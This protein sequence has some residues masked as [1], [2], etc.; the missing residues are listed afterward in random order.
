[1]A[2]KTEHTSE[3]ASSG[4][5][6]RSRRAGWD[7]SLMVATVGLLGALGLQS[8]VGTLYSWWAYRTVPGWEQTGY[9]GFIDVM[10]LIAGPLVIAL[11]V[12]MGLC[13]PK[14]LFSRRT[15]LAVSAGM[16]ALGVGVSV[17]RG[18]FLTGLGVYLGV[19]AFIQVAVVVLTIADAGGLEY[20][21]EGRLAKVGSG[22]LHLGFIVFA[23][24][25]VAL[26]S[27][28]MMMLAFMTSG[29]LLT[30]GSAMSF[31][32]RSSSRG[33]ADER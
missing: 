26:Q 13:V 29:V 23:L 25:I 32:A 20:V 18:S 9:A 31:Y 28:S 30:G 4:T 6:P 21:T 22:L 1:M 11:I 5:G 14:R 2:E 16:L 19:S 33:L 24:T 7:F 12:V 10:N 3:A 27:S 8:L 17:V 15:L